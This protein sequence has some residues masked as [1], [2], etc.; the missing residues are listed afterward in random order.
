M[1][2]HKRSGNLCNLQTV[3]WGLLTAGLLLAS[4]MEHATAEEKDAASKKPSQ[5]KELVL[6]EH[7]LLFPIRAGAPSSAIDLEINGQN[8]REFDAS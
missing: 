8:V 2:D 4:S 7:Y 1:L 3:L 6:K 5:R